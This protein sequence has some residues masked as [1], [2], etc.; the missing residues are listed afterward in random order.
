MKTFSAVARDRNNH[1]NLIRVSAALL[2]MFVH[3][4]WL[5]RTELPIDGVLTPHH[6]L[7]SGAM[8]VD[9]LFSVS[10]FLI[11]AS[12]FN[13]HGVVDFLCAR[14]L[15]VFPG[16]WTMLVVI[17]FGLGVALTTSP[18]NDYLTAKLTWLYLWRWG[19]IMSG[20]AHFLPGLF[21][22]NPLD[23]QVNGSLW[24]ITI[25]W[26]LYLF[27]AGGWLLLS[28]WPV[29]RRRAFRLFIPVVALAL[30]VQN[31]ILHSGDLGAQHSYFF[32]A[33]ST[34]FLFGDRIPVG[35]V[36]L[37][38]S[39]AILA[40]VLALNGP[41]MAVYLA[42]GAYVVLNLA[43]A[44]ARWPLAYNRFGDYSYGL[45]IYAYPI[46]QAVIALK[47]G[48]GV[49]TLALIAT[50]VTLILAVLSW[51]FVEKPALAK[52]DSAARAAESMIEA[53]RARPPLSS[54]AATWTSLRA[55]IRLGGGGEQPAPSE[56]RERVS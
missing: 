38:L 2:V 9:V 17:V 26:R 56:P 45:Y 15:R 43:Y 13:R 6:D 21:E 28:P 22:H 23:A 5:T 1:F 46:T 51:R 34:I 36:P 19:T 16:L 4:F 50:P 20:Y 39:V 47:P 10:G 8:A 29:W 49:A 52:K 53:V 24:T 48:I 25:E 32:F 12:L 35:P 37:A 41:F 31:G 27:F 7:T 11:T 42:L 18:L 40:A 33:G 55:Q 30:F 3:Y 14:C 44:P 54:L